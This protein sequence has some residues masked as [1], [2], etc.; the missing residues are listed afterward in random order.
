M[1]I[2]VSTAGSRGDFEPYVALTQGLI[3][4]GHEVVFAAPRDARGLVAGTDAEFVEMDLE[5]REVLRSEEGRRWLAAGNVE[6]YLAGIAKMLSEA[7]HTIGAAVLAAAEGADVL[8]TGVNTEDYALAVSQSRG[9]P[10]VLGHLTPWLMTDE[11]PQP[12]T[13]QAVP[14]GVPAEQYHL[15]THQVAEDVYWQGK[16]DDI[17][18]FRASLGLPPAPGAALTWTVDLGLPTLQAFSEQ[19]VPRPHDWAPQNTVT[20]FWRLPHAVRERVG[21]AVVPGGLA[22][23]LADG[24]APVFLGFGSMPVLDPQK[25]VDLIVRAA[26]RTGL[27]LL[28]GVGWSDLSGLTGDLPENVRL[29]GAVDHDWLFPRCRAV[30]HHGGAGTTAAGLTA[31][32]PT[33]I[34]TVFSDQPFWGERVSR[35]G[36]GGYANFQEFGLE[37]LVGVLDRLVGDDLRER[38]AAIGE[39]LREEDGVGTAVNLIGKLADRG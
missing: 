29:V 26:G 27:R 21:E 16:K 32:L 9:T 4:A 5:V 19:V 37:H 34:Y 18:E 7:R 39:R 36:V 30:V 24:A 14:D 35:L 25:L 15:Q 38:A 17:N 11:F 3:D 2:G 6:A 33:W 8:V 13:P 31:G 10:V 12:L 28:V 22:D 23:W 20:G 1:R